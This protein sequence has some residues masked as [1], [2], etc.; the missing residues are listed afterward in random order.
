M[1][2]L[3]YIEAVKKTANIKSD[4]ALAQ[5]L[6]VPRQSISHWKNGRTIGNRECFKVAEILGKNPADV[7]RDIEAERNPEDPFWSHWRGAAALVVALPLLITLPEVCLLCKITRPQLTTA[8]RRIRHAFA[9]FLTP[10]RTP[11][12]L[13]A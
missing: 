9:H 4:Y 6:G 10:R 1:K 11:A 13:A 12:P 7:V 5:L 8:V 2:T 3:D